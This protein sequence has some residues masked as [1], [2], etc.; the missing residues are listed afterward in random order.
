[1]LVTRTYLQMTC[2]EEHGSAG[3]V[4]PGLRVERAAVCPASFYRYLYAEVGRAYHWLDRGGW[5]DEQI[6][7]HLARPDISIWVAY[8]GGAP[9]GFFELRTC[10]DGSTEIAYFGLVRDFHGKGLGKQLLSAAI[11]NAWNLGANR[12][13]LH[14]CT[15]DDPAAMPNYLRRGFAAYRQEIYEAAIPE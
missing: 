1:M 9:A 8:H 14:T 13:W 6:R 2:R 3:I 15:L 11:E 4:D 7:A 12:I 5:T 10:E